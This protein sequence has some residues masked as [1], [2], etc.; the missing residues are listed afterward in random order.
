MRLKR[1][2]EPRWC[3]HPEWTGVRLL[4][5]PVGDVERAQFVMSCRTV[6]DGETVFDEMAMTR[7]WF[8][9][10]LEDW[11]GIE[12]P[13]DEAGSPTPMKDLIYGVN[14]FRLFVLDKSEE[15]N[16][17]A[18]QQMEAELK[19]S[20]SSASGSQKSRPRDSRA[21]SAG[22]SGATKESGHHAKNA[23]RA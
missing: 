8:D 12:P 23:G 1:L 21:R 15:L 14:A 2:N 6:T 22:S 13:E 18:Q 11:E 5:R 19:N 17:T 20:P 7:K 9:Y 16:S 4:I 10:A 3:A